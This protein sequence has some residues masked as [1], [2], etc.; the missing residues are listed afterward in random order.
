MLKSSLCCRG[1]GLRG[2]DHT[3]STHYSS[4][5]I[6]GTGNTFIPMGGKKANKQS[7]WAQIYNAYIQHLYL[8][9]IFFKPAHIW[10]YFKQL[11]DNK[12]KPVCFYLI[13][14]PVIVLDDFPNRGDGSG[15]LVQAV[16][17]VVVQRGRVLGVAVGG[18]E[19]NRHC[20]AHLHPGNTSRPWTFV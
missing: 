9:H 4:Y 18:C 14:P 10:N 2:L 20:E 16:R 12:S 7:K 5:S 3:F 15:I 8:A 1:F 11:T 13:T 6:N 19:V 17:V